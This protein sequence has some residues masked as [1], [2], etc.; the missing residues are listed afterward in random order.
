MSIN[1][2]Q[3][4]LNQIWDLVNVIFALSANDFTL[5]GWRYQHSSEGIRVGVR[6]RRGDMEH[7]GQ[8]QGL[9]WW[10][11]S[12]RLIW[13][14]CVH[15]VGARHWTQWTLESCQCVHQFQ[16]GLCW[17]DVWRCVA[18]SSQWEHA[19]RRSAEPFAIP[20]IRCR[21]ESLWYPS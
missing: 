2:T 19:P 3:P 5:T 20:G 6:L 7:A 1:T 18:L 14:V 12:A 16:E 9:R 8:V 21:Y 4:A 11:V 10:W 15:S 17:N 13:S